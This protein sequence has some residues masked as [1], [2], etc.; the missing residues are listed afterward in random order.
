MLL[1][2]DI[3]KSNPERSVRKDDKNEYEEFAH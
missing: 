3:F 2:T 1:L